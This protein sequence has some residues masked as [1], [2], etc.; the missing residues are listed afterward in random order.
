MRENLF[1]PTNRY[2]GAGKIA[3]E[4]PDTHTRGTME[5]VY[6]V[7][8]DLWHNYKAKNYITLFGFNEYWAV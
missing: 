2:R 1:V 3:C 5:N 6:H 4:S 8:H 7:E